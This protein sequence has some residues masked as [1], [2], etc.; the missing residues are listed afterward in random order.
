M[1][2]SELHQ[3]SPMLRTALPLASSL[4]LATLGAAFLAPT[5][6]CA[7]ASSDDVASSA[8]ASTADDLAEAK[9]ILELLGGD[10]GRCSGCHTINAAKIRQWG[11]SMKTI[12]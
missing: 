10:E 2:G 5:T 12:D 9:S 6:G 3:P 4:F 8:H 1:S 7:P 11:N